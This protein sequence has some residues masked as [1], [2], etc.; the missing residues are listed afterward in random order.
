MLTNFKIST[1]LISA[2]VVM[3][4]FIAII[5][6]AGYTDYWFPKAGSDTPLPKRGYSLEFKP[7]G[8]VVG[9]GNYVDD[10]DTIVAEQQK[11]ARDEFIH[12]IVFLHSRHSYLSW[13]FLELVLRFY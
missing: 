4:L 11:T 9:T 6:I 13:S 12:N 8:W 5:G 3:L 7:W 10:I 2:F 1:R